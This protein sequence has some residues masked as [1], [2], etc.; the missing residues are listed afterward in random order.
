MNTS[1]E[2]VR[3]LIAVQAGEWFMVHREGQLDAAQQRAFYAWLAASPMHVEEYLGVALISRHLPAAAAD[4]EMPLEAILEKVTREVGTVAMPGEAMSR[5]VPRERT[6]LVPLWRWA[7]V[8]AALAIIG[9]AV[10]W[11]SG[12]ETKA[13][14]YATQ[15]GEQRTW[16]L[17]DHSKLRL[18]TDTTVT[19]HYNRSERLIELE[20]GEALFEVVH[21][22]AR[23]F[24]V[25]AGTANV[26]DLGTAFDVYRRAHST[27]VTVVEGS[28]AVSA[29]A[30]GPVSV[31]VRS[32]EQVQVLDGKPPTRATPADVQS[33]TA[34]LRREIV[35]EQ[36]PLAAVAA[37]F[38]RYSKTP[39]EIETPDLRSLQISG[40]F[41]A[42][43]TETFVAF[44]RSLEGVNVEVTQSRIRVSRQ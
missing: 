19:V 1:E 39:I 31:R 27:L 35:F 4:P 14:R 18:N 22:P 36:E 40:A 38:N 21:D 41:S 30:A 11:R 16:L 5:S 37:E 33:S 8:P 10:F 20:H 2:Q 17:A 42:D 3:E 26:V 23:P 44:L 29:P 32:G 25:L 43:D 34:W 12:T 15:H 24:H 13:E 9:S 28:V 6:G 7:A